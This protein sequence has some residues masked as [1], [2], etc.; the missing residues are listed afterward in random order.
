VARCEGI[1]HPLE[2]ADGGT[3]LAGHGDRIDQATGQQT[4]DHLDQIIWRSH[5]S[6]Q[7]AREQALFNGLLHG[8]AGRG[9][10]DTATRQF[11]GKIG[12]DAAFRP[13]NEPDHAVARDALA[14]G[15]AAAVQPVEPL[16]CP[17]ASAACHG[18]P[19]F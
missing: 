15:D 12:D 4:L 9:N 11:L 17:V 16:K 1:A 19:Y 3:R 14:R 13:Q 2:P 5:L 8:G 6:L 10:P 7:P 18:V